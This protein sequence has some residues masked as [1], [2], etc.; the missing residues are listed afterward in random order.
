[1]R[2]IFDAGR[3]HG[4]QNHG[5]LLMFWSGRIGFSHEDRDLA[6]RIAGAGGP[7]LTA[8]ND[9]V[10]AVAHDAGFDVGGVGGGNSWL[11]HRE[12][13][14][15]FACQ[16]R[17]QPAFFLFG[18]PVACEHFHVAGIGRRTVEDFRRHR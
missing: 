5:L 17:L 12:A 8:I 11:G 18:R 9:V 15:D 14:S 3:V 2:S 10:I 7:P 16:E 4:H 1:M 6:A 13:G